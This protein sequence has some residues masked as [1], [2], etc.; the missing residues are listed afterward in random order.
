VFL[1]TGS[2]ATKQIPNRYSSFICVDG[3]MMMAILMIFGTFLFEEVFSF[4][5]INLGFMIKFDFY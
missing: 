2:S 5:N 1:L 4:G 3:L